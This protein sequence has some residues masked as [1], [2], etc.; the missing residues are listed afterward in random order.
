MLNVFSQAAIPGIWRPEGRDHRP[1]SAGLPP[2]GAEQSVRPLR[3]FGH[4]PNVVVALHGGWT[5]LDTLHRVVTAFVKEESVYPLP[6]RSLQRARLGLPGD[7]GLIRGLR[8]V[9]NNSS[10]S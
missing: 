4:F 7:E 2:A 3:R 6:S 9:C 5:T 8:Q 10:D 1:H